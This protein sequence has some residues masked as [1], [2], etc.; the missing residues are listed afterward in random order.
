MKYIFIFSSIFFFNQ[1]KAQNVYNDIAYKQA[2]GL[3]S[4]LQLNDSFLI[5]AFHVNVLLDQKKGALRKQDMPLNL[6]TRGL[7][8]I[9]NT[10]DSLY[11]SFLPSDKYTYYLSHKNEVLN[12]N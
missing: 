11:Q 1:S 9:E 10:R 3:V 12:N 7:Q 6:L 2:K 5:K 4:V 8:K